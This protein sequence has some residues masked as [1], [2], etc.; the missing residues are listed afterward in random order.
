VG[1]VDM[2]FRGIAM[3]PL[4]WLILALVVYLVYKSPTTASAILGG[5]GHLF[6]TVGNGLEVFLDDIRKSGIHV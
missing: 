3:K 2:N 6:V 4:G 5:F 1:E